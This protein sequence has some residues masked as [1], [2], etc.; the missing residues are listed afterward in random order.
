MKKQ[1]YFTGSAFGKTIVENIGSKYLQFNTFSDLQ[2]ITVY[3]Y[4]ENGKTTFNVFPLHLLP[5]LLA[6]YHHGSH[7]VKNSTVYVR[8]YMVLPLSL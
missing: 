3:Y 6:A 8:L 1:T 2:S 7:F 5:A 4:T